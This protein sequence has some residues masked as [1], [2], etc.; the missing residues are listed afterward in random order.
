MKKKLLVK[1]K[2]PRTT[3]IFLLGD[4]LGCKNLKTK[5]SI[6]SKRTHIAPFSIINTFFITTYHPF[7]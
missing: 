1:K 3:E 6:A 4:N 2:E 7:T 5:T